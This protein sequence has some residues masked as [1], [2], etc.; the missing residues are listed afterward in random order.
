MCCSTNA[1]VTI[2]GT[3]ERRLTN[4]NN[5]KEASQAHIARVKGHKVVRVVRDREVLAACVAQQRCHACQTKGTKS[6]LS[7]DDRGVT[8]GR[9]SCVRAHLMACIPTSHHVATATRI[10][11]TI[12]STSSSDP[13]V[14]VA[15]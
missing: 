11:L 8:R 1:T 14:L 13:P 2:S 4:N 3:C 5:N 15:K 10:A 9:R 6:L 7:P 12:D